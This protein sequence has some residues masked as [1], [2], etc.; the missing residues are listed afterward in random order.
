MC[1]MRR[2]K[3]CACDCGMFPV[4]WFFIS[5]TRLVQLNSR[6]G[7]GVISARSSAVHSLAWPESHGFGLARAGS[8]FVKPQ[9]KPLMAWLQLG[10]AQA[11][12]FEWKNIL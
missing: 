12:A 9:A 11:V 5:V 8:G 6:K 3:Q 10:L 4:S 1:S 2:K 7:L